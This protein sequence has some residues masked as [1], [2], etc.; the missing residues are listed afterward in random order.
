[1]IS[2]FVAAWNELTMAR[3]LVFGNRSTAGA[4]R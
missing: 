3:A 1:V 4:I 2:T